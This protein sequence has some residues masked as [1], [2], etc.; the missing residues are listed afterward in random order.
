MVL[1]YGIQIG[2]RENAGV[3]NGENVGEPRMVVPAGPRY[4]WSW[5]TRES[6]LEREETVFGDGNYEACMKPRKSWGV[7][8][9]VG[10]WH[11]SWRKRSGD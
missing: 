2:K 8:A 4:G 9:E 1:D 10:W 5:G 3:K 11:E 7:A 6:K